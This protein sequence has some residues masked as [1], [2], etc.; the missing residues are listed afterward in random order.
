MG[1]VLRRALLAGAVVLTGATVGSAPASG[2]EPTRERECRCV[3]A[4]GEPVERCVCVNVPSVDRLFAV[5]PFV[6]R[7]F[8]GVTIDYGQGPEADARGAE[9]RE[10]Q[11]DGPADR[12]GL[13]PGD[14]VVRVD[15]HSLFDPLDGPAE[16]RL[17]EAT[18]LPVQRFVR[19]V[20]QLEPGEP[21]EIEFLRDGETRT[22][23]VVPDPAPGP[24]EAVSGLRFF[25]DEALPES[26]FRI[27]PHDEG[28]GLFRFEAPRLDSLTRFDTEP[29]VARFR[30]D[31]CMEPQGEGE[32]MRVRIL[33][34]DD[35]VDGVEFVDLNPELGEYFGTAEGVLVARVADGSTLGL[36]AG[37]VLLAVDGRE[38]RSAEHAL[39]VLGS[40]DPDE[41]LR[42]R[43]VRKGAETEVLGRRR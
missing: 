12:A 36:R 3:D 23:E 39:R 26:P 19:R 13:R 17:D 5:A 31:P 37:D 41:E 40:Y 24:L 8:V 22:V 7:S 30:F 35:C 25:G 9:I 10:V 1:R 32:R 27:R 20:G 15:G 33:G 2:Q 11:D 4:R 43:V 38:V 34:R 42:L 16:A 18:S 29:F 6:R 28:A 21:V 14:L